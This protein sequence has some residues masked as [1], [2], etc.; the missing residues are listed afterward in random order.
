VIAVSTA[1]DCILLLFAAI[2]RYGGKPDY[3]R[4]NAPEEFAE[5]VGQRVG[6]VIVG[7]W[8][9][10]Q[11]AAL[12][13]SLVA[14]DATPWVARMF[15]FKTFGGATML[16]VSPKCSPRTAE[17]S[18]HF[19]GALE[20]LFAELRDQT[21]VLDSTNHLPISRV[22]TACPPDSEPHR[23]TIER[24]AHDLSNLVTVILGCG[25]VL[26]KQ[27][28]ND[29]GSRYVNDLMTA[30]RRVARLLVEFKASS[31]TRDPEAVD[32]AMVLTTSRAALQEMAG[33]G[34]TISLQMS[35]GSLMVS[36]DR[37]RLESV[38]AS[39]VVH[40]RLTL[41]RGHALDISLDQIVLPIEGMSWPA[42]PGRYVV[43]TFRYG[44]KAAQ[45]PG[46]KLPPAVIISKEAASELGLGNVCA[47]IERAGGAIAVSRKSGRLAAIMV[48]LPSAGMTGPQRCP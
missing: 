6:D 11:F 37:R 3:R 8:P 22:M 44:A 18:D 17:E 36:T 5:V 42:T 27:L 16:A 21:T 24:I 7:L 30:A 31:E 4:I 45:E 40:A 35:A 14:R 47:A 13:A 2:L 20:R 48:F 12:A 1:M 23:Q 10:F 41:R 34:L 19:T 39:I 9:D 29:V 38:A 15:T 28:H 26:A 33:D 46:S 32:A 43:L 25:E